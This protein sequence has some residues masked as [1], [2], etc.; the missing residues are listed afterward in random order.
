MSLGQGPAGRGGCAVGPVNGTAG[1]AEPRGP[2]PGTSAPARQRPSSE[3]GRVLVGTAR[4]LA[5]GRGPSGRLGAHSLCPPPI[6]VTHLLG[7]P[8]PHTHSTRPSPQS[9]SH[10]PFP[11]LA[12]PNTQRSLGC[13][14]PVSRWN[15]SSG[16]AGNWLCAWWFPSPKTAPCIQQALSEYLWLTPPPL[17]PPRCPVH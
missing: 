12:L 11:L 3:E 14:H 15:L 2:A 17:S 8:P 7:P 16:R 1:L 5:L 13:V 6:T 9:G 4:Q 10:A